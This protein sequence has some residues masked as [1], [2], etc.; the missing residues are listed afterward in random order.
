[1]KTILLSTSVIFHTQEIFRVSKLDPNCVE[2]HEM[3]QY[4]YVSTVHP[5][6]RVADT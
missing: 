6:V 4:E 1:M 5:P 3:V 2:L